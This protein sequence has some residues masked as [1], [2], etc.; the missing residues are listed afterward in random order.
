MLLRL[1]EKNKM[2]H[3]ELNKI[4]ND[5]ID[6]S[7]RQMENLESF[8]QYIPLVCETLA[9]YLSINAIFSLMDL[10]QKLGNMDLSFFLLEHKYL[11]IVSNIGVNYYKVN[12]NKIN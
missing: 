9:Y 2:N 12:E 11:K 6:K 1:G 5:K 10:N 3:Q 7:L 4:F 8:I